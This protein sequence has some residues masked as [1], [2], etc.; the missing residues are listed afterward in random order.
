M[1]C[2]YNNVGR[3]QLLNSLLIF[4]EPPC[5]GLHIY[6]STLPSEISNGPPESHNHLHRTHTNSR[7][8]E[9]CGLA[10]LAYEVQCFCDA[11]QI[12][13][14]CIEQNATPSQ[15]PFTSSEQSHLPKLLQQSCHQ[16]LNS[17][18]SKKCEIPSLIRAN[19]STP[20]SAHQRSQNCIVC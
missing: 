4:N 7:V 11:Y 17:V 20:F 6:R 12:I 10:A 2:R 18:A 15:R 8:D 3:T 19:R 13:M 9:L 1:Y 16:P 5:S 14:K